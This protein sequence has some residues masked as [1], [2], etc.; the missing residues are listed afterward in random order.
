MLIIFNAIRERKLHLRDRG[1]A[2]KLRPLN[3]RGEENNQTKVFEKNVE[4]LGRFL[5]VAQILNQSV[6]KST[7]CPMKRG[8]N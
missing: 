4:E 3:C 7:I 5:A 8:D 1:K 2:I 6:L